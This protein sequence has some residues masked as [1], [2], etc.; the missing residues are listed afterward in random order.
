MKN[1]ALRFNELYKKY[2]N[3]V[4][5]KSFVFLICLFKTLFDII[6]CEKYNNG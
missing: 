3:K 5:N 2:R 4:L 6:Y 1:I